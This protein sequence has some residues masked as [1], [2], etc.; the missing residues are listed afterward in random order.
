MC[1]LLF[2]D[3]ELFYL[4]QQNWGN[5]AILFGPN[6]ASG[7]KDCNEQGH[8]KQEHAERMVINEEAM[9]HELCDNNTG[10]GKTHFIP[11]GVGSSTPT[12]FPE[13]CRLQVLCDHSSLLSI[14]RV[15]LFLA[16]LGL[17]PFYGMEYTSPC[18]DHGQPVQC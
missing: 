4:N 1:V 11:S 8:Y 2:I 15:A 13:G 14:L 3:V 5:P 6:A 7:I 12:D 17:P 9:S 18:R 16:R 10:T